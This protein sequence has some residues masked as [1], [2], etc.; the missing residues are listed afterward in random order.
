MLTY[1]LENVSE[2]LKVLKREC[3]NILNIFAYL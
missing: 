2:A 3:L 1:L